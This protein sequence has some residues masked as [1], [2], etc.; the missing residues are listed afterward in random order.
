MQGTLRDLDVMF[1]KSF[2]EEFCTTPREKVT[3]NVHTFQHLLT[4]R[5]RNGPLWETSTDFEAIFSVV[6]RC[7]QVGTRNV[8]KQILRNFYLHDL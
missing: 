8:L 6:C 7:F 4:A 2:E 1:A 3:I 5:R